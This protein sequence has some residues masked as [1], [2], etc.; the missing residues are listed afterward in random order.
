MLVRQQAASSTA[1][2]A[3]LSVMRNNAPLFPPARHL[4]QAFAHVVQ[5][6][7]DR[8][9]LI[10]GQR[11]LSYRELDRL[12]DV[13]AQALVKRGVGRG[14]FVGLH[15]QRSAEAVVAILAILKLGATYAPFDPA[16][17][18]VRLAEQAKAAQIQVLMIAQAAS[19][20]SWFVGEVLRVDA[21][22]AQRC[23][24]LPPLNLHPLE[25]AHVIYT[26]GSTNEPKGVCITHRGVLD[27]IQGA[28]YCD[29][30]PDDVVYHGMSIAFDGSTFEIWG[31]LLSGACLVVAPPRITGEEMEALVN[32]HG[33]TI[34][35]LTTGLFNALGGPALA[36]MRSLRVLMAGGDVMSPHVANDY[37]ASGGRT[38]VNGYG[39]TEIT[40]FSHCHVITAPS[41]EPQPIPVGSPVPGTAAYVLDAEGKAVGVGEEGELF[42]AGTGLAQGYLGRPALTAERFLP[43]PFAAD[44]SRMYRSGDL[45]R[46]SRKRWLEFLV[47]VDTQVKIR[48]FRVEL[49]EIETQLRASGALSDACV[50][51]AKRA[52]DMA[53]LHAYVVANQSDAGVA[54]PALLEQLRARLPEY[55]VPRGVSFLDALP[56]TINGKVDR[57]ALA[58][59]W[60]HEQE[61]G[62][63]RTPV[64]DAGTDE[65]EHAVLQLVRQLLEQPLATL[66]D[67]FLDLG[68]DSISAMRFC[69]A[70][71]EQLGAHLPLI[72]LFEAEDL[73]QLVS[74]VRQGS[75]SPTAGVAALSL[76]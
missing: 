16:A 36:R 15:M 43:D 1:A 8:T 26:S 7:P 52:G 66:G 64:A 47:R 63:Q 67:N 55:M 27:L 19:A 44:G 35:L 24:P 68:G 40:T 54:A 37:L 18:G 76:A 46:Q 62:T 65:L 60:L 71:N 72:S 39:P 53:V 11:H 42:I 33:V 23:E 32:R 4:A 14:H 73:K 61:R 56:L 29:F 6:Q 3:G 31:A 48:G 10:D 28:N 50:I 13:A 38:L 49:G 9:A 34:M 21:G 22:T 74:L 2:A 51:Y 69:A 59:A 25:L 70:V 5:A 30:M 20:P 17:P 41:T 75:A 45:V 58:E 57:H 12:S